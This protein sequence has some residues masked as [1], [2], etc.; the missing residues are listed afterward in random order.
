MAKHTAA[1]VE[2]SLPKA[3]SGYKERASAVKAAHDSTKQAIKADPMTSD[4]AKKDKL[5][6]LDKDTR[7][8]LDAIKDEQVTYEKGL[9]DT[10]ERELR[11]NQPADANSVLLRRDAADRVRKITDKQ[12]AMDILQDALANSDESMA[13]AIGTRARNAAWLD[14]AEAYQAAYPATADS[15]AA[16]AYVEAN[17]SGAAYNLSNQI[18][19]SA[20]LH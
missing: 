9:R 8:K 13:H 16:L 14:V 7:A 4:L 12:E 19:Y 17:T 5:E 3:Q 1:S 10:I 11:G 20:P 2:T 15:A 6:A 18:T